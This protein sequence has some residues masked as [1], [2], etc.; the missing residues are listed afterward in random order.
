M[1]YYIYFREQDKSRLNSSCSWVLYIYCCV[2]EFGG[3][4]L[5]L[6]EQNVRRDWSKSSCVV[7]ER[8]EGEGGGP[9]VFMEKKKKKK[10]EK[11]KYNNNNKE[12]PCFDHYF[13]IHLFLLLLH[14]LHELIFLLILTTFI[15]EPD[16]YN[17]GT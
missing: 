1:S 14:L 4:Q 7:V 12:D 11:K 15:L 13:G 6:P 8:V 2:K 10:K 3:E 9:T 5:I 16:P 17:A